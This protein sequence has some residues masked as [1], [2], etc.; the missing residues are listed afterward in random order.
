VTETISGLVWTGRFGG[1]VLKFPVAV[2]KMA[3]RKR[4]SSKTGMPPGALVHL[5]ERKL[6]QTSINLIEYSADQIIE[7]R[8]DSL[9]ECQ[10]CEPTLPCQWLNVYGLHEPQVMAEIGR[11]FK[12]HPLVLEDI[13]NT[14]QRPKLDEYADYLFVVARF[15]DYDDTTMTVASE[16]VSM[17]IGH[18]FVITFQERP[19]GNF[20]P[21]RDRLR[22]ERGQ[23]RQAGVDYLA[24]A[25]LDTIVD[26]YFAVLERIGERAERI[27]EDLMRRPTTAVLE[28]L[29]HLK[30]ETIML[31][32]AVWPLRE[33]INSMTRGNAFFG[34]EVQPYLR[35]VYD[36]TVHVIESLETIRDLLAGMLDIY[37]SS[38]SNR[39][40]GEVRTLTV[41][42]LI[43]MPAT[44][45]SGI[46]GM[47]FRVM[48]L[49]GNPVGFFI[50]LAMMLAI[51]ITL[52]LIFWRRRWLG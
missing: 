30:R 34:A 52:G 51:A 50:A 43:F 6:E 15:F 16:Q 8:F 46:F 41:F 33:V 17:V 20:N 29:H 49:L 47:N 2:T 35:D 37:L 13:L 18:N 36:H 14:D 42:A 1:I 10:A 9:A 45:I 26:R 31:R 39:L 4:R 11:R 19:T 23:I 40:N 21:V 44:L 48:P 28:T 32:R 22:Q 25:L 7:K 5:G 3:V 38:V 27:E 24:Y 12:L